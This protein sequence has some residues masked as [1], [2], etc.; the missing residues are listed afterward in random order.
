MLPSIHQFSVSQRYSGISDKYRERTYSAA[1]PELRCNNRQPDNRTY[2]RNILDLRRAIPGF[3]KA[4]NINHRN[5]QP[6]E[7]AYAVPL[8]PAHR[9]AAVEALEQALKTREANQAREPK[10]RSAIATSW[11]FHRFCYGS[12]FT[13]SIFADNHLDFIAANRQ[14][15][16]DPRGESPLYKIGVVTFQQPEINEFFQ[17]ADGMVSFVKGNEDNTELIFAPA[18]FFQESQF[19]DIDV[20]YERNC[21]GRIIDTS[22]LSSTRRLLARN[23]GRTALV[24]DCW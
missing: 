3:K 12:Q 17:A 14:F 23:H 11:N 8:A 13:L 16:F 9:K 7:Q 1:G 22:A 15:E 6:I 21:I 20:R 4:G 24:T 5:A 19:L 10:A 18:V 2:Q